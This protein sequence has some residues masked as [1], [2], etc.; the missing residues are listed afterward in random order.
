MDLRPIL[1]FSFHFANGC[2]FFDE[3][4]FILFMKATFASG[5]VR[6]QY[7]TII[8]RPTL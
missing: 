6:L 4:T 8:K 1:K 5:T 2:D 3:K 7:L